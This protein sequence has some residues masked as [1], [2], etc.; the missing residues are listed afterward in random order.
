M[1]KVYLITDGT[2]YKIGVTTK[3]T[4]KSRLRELQT[5]NSSKIQ[6]EGSWEVYDAANILEQYL[7]FELRDHRLV[8]EWF[9]MNDAVKNKVVTIL[10][11][12]TAMLDAIDSEEGRKWFSS[13]LANLQYNI[14]LT[15]KEKAIKSDMLLAEMANMKFVINNEKEDTPRC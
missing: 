13:T 15:F 1:S 3:K 5:G 12:F 6:E 4:V 7:H 8:G 9:V 2:A 11:H 14:N 10:K